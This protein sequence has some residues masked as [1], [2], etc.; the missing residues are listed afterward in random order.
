MEKLLQCQSSIQACGEMTNFFKVYGLSSSFC[1]CGQPLDQCAF[2]SNIAQKF[3]ESGFSL[4]QFPDY[5]KIQ[6]KCEAHWTH[7]GSLFSS[8]YQH[9]YARIMEPFWE[10]VTRHCTESKFLVDSSKTAYTR[11][12][13]PI[14]ISQLE[15]FRMRIIH[16]VRD[17]RGV[18]WSVKKGLNRSLEAGKDIKTLFPV[19]RAVA[20]WMYANRVADRLQRY[21]G[22]KNY[23]LVRYED[24]VED[25][26][27]V[28]NRISTSWA[29]DLHKSI[30]VAHEA[31]SGSE[32]QIPLMHQL[33]GNRMR[34][35]THLSIRPDYTW[36]EQLNFKTNAI[37]KSITMPLIKK[38][39]YV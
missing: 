23:C 32:I 18:V 34:F 29:I 3:F 38:Y 7:G 13:R 20:G 19:T 16:L 1:S 6:K 8:K 4:S 2:W 22:E 26:V 39:G 11:P 5:S 15:K 17:P 33:T 35:S 37:V 9:M 28:L 21:F 24:L 25:P 14:A 27:Y 12:F 30:R 31:K 10:S 36:R